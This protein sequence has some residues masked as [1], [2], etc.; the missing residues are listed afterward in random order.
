MDDSGWSIIDSE[1]SPIAADEPRSDVMAASVEE[2]TT[3]ALVVCAAGVV[4]P[5][6]QAASGTVINARRTKERRMDRP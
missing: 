4:V 2:V 1:G 6:P 5:L 3:E